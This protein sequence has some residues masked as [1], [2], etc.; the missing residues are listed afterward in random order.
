M[1]VQIDSEALSEQL[2][3]LA[4]FSDATVPAVSRVVFSAADNRAR[5]Y[6]KGLLSDAGLDIREDGVGNTFARWMGSDPKLPAVATGSHIDAIP[7]AGMYDGTVG[8]LGGLAA[9]VALKSGGFQPVR[10]IELVVFT[11]EEPTRFG[12]GCLGSRMM[13]G[14]LSPAAAT[15]LRDTNG[16]TLEELRSEAGFTVELSQVKCLEGTY[17]AFIELHIEQGPLLDKSAIPIGVVTGIAAPASLRI[18]LTGEGGHAGAV[19]MNERK[20]AFLAAA[21]IALGV[22]EVARNSG[23]ADSVATT[24]VCEVFPGAVN[25]IPSRVKLEIDIRDT[26]LIR[27]DEMLTSIQALS[28]R[29]ASVRGVTIQKELVNADDP[30]ATSPTVVEAIE[31]ACEALEIGH[32]RMVSRAYHDSLFMARVAPTGMIFIPSK[33]GISHRPDEFS[34]AK[35]IATGA[36]VLAHTLVRLSSA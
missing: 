26:N 23:S 4:S 9:I 31:D 8:V 12:I 35:D 18:T 21:E 7:N 32:C 6:L 15:S 36:L 1:K 22:E 11:A 30:A 3:K 27:R 2:L 16:L 20:D 29:A 25:S 34:S 13:S 17:A 10:S 19:L 24:G 14:V 33:D 5:K 28:D